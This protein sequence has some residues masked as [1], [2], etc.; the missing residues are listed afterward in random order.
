MRE[1]SSILN[2]TL[3]WLRSSPG[4]VREAD[5][6]VYRLGN[7]NLA[8]GVAGLLE[9]AAFGIAGI[10]SLRP[11]PELLPLTV[12]STVVFAA[13]VLLGVWLILAFY[14]ERLFVSDSGVRHRGCIRT[15]TM[16]FAELTSARW[17]YSPKLVGEIRIRG[18]SLVLRSP[19]RKL[20]VYFGGFSN[21]DRIEL[22]A[23][24]RSTIDEGLQEQWNEFE[25]GALAPRG[26]I[27]EI[28]L[29]SG[30]D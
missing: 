20:V 7:F 17:R 5:A 11:F 8:V 2:R 6:T 29:S 9:F 10:V 1:R 18:Q 28:G 13:F 19:G 22:I 21:S 12:F 16:V 15:R 24:F 27:A 23:F 3:V 25:A 30:K 26:R 4:K 14:R